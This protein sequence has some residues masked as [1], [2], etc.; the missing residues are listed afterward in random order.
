MTS[1]VIDAA[2]ADARTTG[3][4]FLWISSS[5]NI[6]PASGALKAA[7]RPALAPLVM[8][9][10]SSSLIFLKITQYPFAIAAPI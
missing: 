9:N 2:I 8:R 3:E 5:E 6:T 1:A 4:K 10:F 7:A